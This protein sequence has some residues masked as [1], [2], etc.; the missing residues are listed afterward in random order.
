MPVNQIL[1]A[2]VGAFPMI[3]DSLLRFSSTGDEY[4]MAFAH[5]GKTLEYRIDANT[6]VVTDYLVKDHED[7]VLLEAEMSR[8]TTAG[9]IATPQSLRISFPESRRSI[10]LVYKQVSLNEDVSCSFIVPEGVKIIKR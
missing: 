6:F 9:D 5:A 2:L 7:K 8:I 3:Q 4:L 1:G 10:S